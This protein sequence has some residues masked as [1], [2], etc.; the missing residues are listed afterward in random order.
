MMGS[1]AIALVL[2]T[3][4]VFAI[5]GYSHKVDSETEIDVHICKDMN[6]RVF[7]M[8]EASDFEEMK[9]LEVFDPKSCM[10]KKITRLDWRSLR[11]RHRRSTFIF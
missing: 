7:F 4:L 11:T 2:F 6:K 9:K 10:V 8:G 3:L 1:N 5:Y